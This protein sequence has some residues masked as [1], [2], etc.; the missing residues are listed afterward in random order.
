MQRFFAALVL[1]SLAAVSAHADTTTS[2]GDSGGEGG[3]P[4]AGLLQAPEANLF[5]GGISQGIEIRI[6]PGR[7]AA[8]PNVGLG[9]SSAGGGPGAFG[10]GWSLPMGTIERNGKWGVPRCAGSAGFSKTDEFVLSLNGSAVELVNFGP[11]PGGSTVYRPRTDQS[12][13]EALRKT[14]DSWEVFDRSG[15]RFKFGT[16]AQARR[17]G[18]NCAAQTFVWALTQIED[19]NDNVVD[20]TYRTGENTLELDKIQYGGTPANPAFQVRFEYQ[21]HPMPVTSYR[22]GTY[23]VIDHLVDRIHVEA[24][25]TEGGSFTSVR[26]YDLEYDDDYTSP[27]APANCSAPERVLL[28]E[29]SVND[30]MPTQS[31]EYASG[32]FGFSTTASQGGPGGAT[33]LRN[34]T[35]GFDVEAS[36][37][38]MNGDGRLDM[39]RAEQAGNNAYALYIGNPSGGISGTAGTWC[40]NQT[41]TTI[42]GNRLRKETDF[43]AGFAYTQKETTDLTGDGLPDFVDA[44]WSTTEWR[45][46]PGTLSTTCPGVTGTVPGFDTTPLAW[47]AVGQHSV[48]TEK[49]TISGD[50]YVWV[51]KRLVDMNADGR[52][53]LLIADQSTGEWSVYLNN[54]QTFVDTG[55]AGGTPDLDYG[56]QGAISQEVKNGGIRRTTQD[57]FDFNGD[58]LPDRVVGFEVLSAYQYLVSLNNGESFDAP[59]IFGVPGTHAIRAVDNSNGRTITDFVDVNGDGLPDRVRVV[60]D[61]WWVSL[62]RGTSLAPE[63]D[64]GILGEIRKNNGKG[65]TK[66]DMVD[67]NHDGLVDRVDASGGSWS[68]RLGLPTT[69]PAVRPYLLTAAHNGIGGWFYPTYQP[70]TRFTNTLLPFPSWVVT[71]TRRTDGLCTGTATAC[72]DSGNEI[73]RTYS[74][75]NGY[76][77]PATREFRGFGRVTESIPWFSSS[78]NA[79][80]RIVTFSQA[81]HTRGQ[82]LTDETWGSLFSVGNVVMSR[83]TNTWA[84]QADGSRTQVYLQEAKS[85]D[86]DPTGVEPAV[87]RL[88]RNAAP[89]VY[90]RVTTRTT[91]PCGAS[92]TATCSGADPVGAVTTVSNWATPSFTAGT[93]PAVRERPGSIAVSYM[94]PSCTSQTLTQQAFTY[95]WPEGNVLT[96]TTNG[97][98]T[99]G[100]NATVT[101][102]YGNYG[103]MTS[104]TDPRT[105]QSTSVFS[106]TPFE[107]FPSSETNAV[108][109]TVQTQWDLRHGK[110]KQVTGPNG[111]VTQA[112]YDAAGRVVCEAKPDQSCTGGPGV[113]GVEYSYV[114]GNPGAPTW[115]GKLSYVQ[116]KTREPNNGTSTLP[117]YLLTRT[118]FDALGRERATATW[119]VLG[120]DTTLSW[121][122]TK[123]ID[124]DPVSRVAKLYSP[125][126]TGAASTGSVGLAQSPSSAA[127]QYGYAY[128]IVE[129]SNRV[130]QLTTPDGYVTETQYSAAWTHVTD[131]EGNKTSSKVDF[132]GREVQ[133]KLYDGWT[134]VAMQYDYTYDGLGRLLT[135]TV[136][137]STVTNT[138]DALGRKRQVA[139][140]DSGTWH[141]RFDLNGNLTLQDDPKT[142][143][144]TE[145]CY[146]KGN[147]AVLQCSYPSDGTTASISCPLNNPSVNASCGSGTEIARFTYDTPPGDTDCGG[148]GRVGQLTSVIDTSGGE[149][150]AYDKRGNVT[151]QKKTI[152]HNANP[153][154]A[155]T[156]F[157]YDDADHVT[158]VTYPD[159]SPA[160]AHGYQADGLPDAIHQVVTGVEYD[161][162]GRA[163]RIVSARNV[164]DLYGYDTTGV[165]NF[166]LQTIQTKQTS[167]GTLY[168]NLGHAYWPRGKLKEVIDY[169]DA[170]TA[171]S[172]AASYCYDGVGRLTKVDRDPAGGSNPCTST[173]DETFSHGSNGN[174][175]AKNGSS[176]GFAAGPHQPTSYGTYSSITYDP[177]G[178][179]T[180]KDKGSGN[181]DE[182][183]YDARGLLVE[184]KRYT[185]GSVS[186]SQTNL[187]DY[188]GNRVVRAPSSGAGATIRTY[189]RYADASGGNLTKYF[190]LGDKLIGSWTVSAPTLSDVDPETILPPPAVELPPQLLVPAAGLV[191]LLLFLPI[192]GRQRIGVRLSLARSAAMSVV[193][194]TASAPVA[195]VAACGNPPPP[196]RVFHVDRLGSTQVV[197]DY[198][199]ALYIQARYYAYGEIRG[200][201][202]A[203]GNPTAYAQDARFEFTG[204]ETDFA[205]LDYAGAR[206]F[207]PE[208]AQFGSHDPAGQFASPYAYGPGDPI[209]G[210][211]PSGEI[212]EILIAIDTYHET[213]SA[214]AATRA[215]LDATF[216]NMTGG[217]YGA[218]KAQSNDQ[219]GRYMADYALNFLTFGGHG[220]VQSLQDGHYVTGVV[221][222]VLCAY[223]MAETISGVFVG[224]GGSAPD[225]PFASLGGKGHSPDSVAF[226]P[227]GWTYEE[228][229]LLTEEEFNYVGEVRWRNVNGKEV[230]SAFV[231]RYGEYGT[232]SEQW[233]FVPAQG[234]SPFIHIVPGGAVSRGAAALLRTRAGAAMF[235]RGGIWNV[236]RLRV[237][238]SEASGKALQLGKGRYEVFR[239]AVGSGK[240]TKHILDIPLRQIR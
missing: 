28:C 3:G 80:R 162:F 81:A 197:T 136:G 110:E 187:Y 101:S 122:V 129:P 97:D 159:A 8:T 228:L 237:G 46:Y 67:W 212:F 27:P 18:F 146:D 179:R 168:L 140:P 224:G 200:R 58:G 180:L 186:S 41:G 45:V 234:A 33:W 57:L 25:T 36:V 226:I 209:N 230:A 111:E 50:E 222:L 34:A 118:Y 138:Y 84:T 49:E 39:V 152:Q 61:R 191:L 121:A 1:G 119:R 131:P 16:T 71:A 31:F 20:L 94:T 240:N 109:H 83:K 77:D 199:G 76:F 21:T 29:V 42:D 2:V 73:Q 69:G 193:F 52:A 40:A 174:L 117:G 106:G 9:Y 96:A 141:S 173:P 89:D 30:G 38:D 79:G 99:T 62:N 100:G 137:G 202:N 127:T 66:T 154:T 55:I 125:Y 225:S 164:E 51:W 112:T 91:L 13:L 155:K 211:D 172:N 157:T 82:I 177:N 142:G 132:A 182:L 12:F 233:G 95:D 150:W 194:L 7:K 59:I 22:G 116:T 60:S 198:N 217:I 24:K 43:N 115:E 54:G 144:R 126:S 78:G 220:A 232:L 4:F 23:E 19:P 113:P 175:T 98:A 170:G 189:S 163:T 203:A 5:T 107:L 169:R 143:Q 231:E 183:V 190:Y 188:A 88:D 153:T 221:G 236:G 26:I 195:L 219:V 130:R 215:G 93:D 11:G 210:T 165:D 227:E 134:T 139:D 208:L 56:A 149:C 37:M 192:G 86:F 102:G 65:N 214:R 105:A 206:F 87:C 229:V 68:I 223:G 44:L 147:R 10:E 74:Y 70:S 124:Y 103:N 120:S 205:G 32:V 176:F 238:L 204:Y 48:V 207:D 63:Q 47:A 135:T 90:G 75:E 72:R 85:E 14:D 181:K 185:S 239:I 53:D 151:T 133:R 156:V 167:T 17:V 158:S 35:Q 114:F 123:Q 160:V 6:P 104:V 218:V 92:V 201:F 213:G 148:P 196:V 161:L 235:G 128:V 184:V 178:S 145:S 216:N 15:M 64:W 166:R 171:R 108:G